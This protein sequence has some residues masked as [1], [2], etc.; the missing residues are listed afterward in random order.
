[1][2][3]E[4][5]TPADI[6]PIRKE[7]KAV[8]AVISEFRHQPPPVPRCPT[9][10]LSAARLSEGRERQQAGLRDCQRRFAD[11]RLEE[12]DSAHFI[13]VEQPRLIADRTRQLVGA[14]S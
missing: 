6:A 8:A 10:V 7:V 13:Q 11:G 9:I 14:S 5:F 3:A 12:A 4:D 2:L 1:M